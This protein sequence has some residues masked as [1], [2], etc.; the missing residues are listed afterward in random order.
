MDLPKFTDRPRYGNEDSD[1]E[2]LD[3]DPTAEAKLV[4]EAVP[5]TVREVKK[6]QR[7]ARDA[8]WGLL[9][10]IFWVDARQSAYIHREDL[11]GIR[12]EFEQ[13][14][15]LINGK[16]S[17]SDRALPAGFT[18]AARERS[19]GREDSGFQNAMGG[20]HVSQDS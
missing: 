5:L 11:E 9:D 13:A 6:L 2:L 16:L 3:L 7:H 15:Q 1:G 19:R 4:A 17:G 20:R 10:C 18:L 12:D 8:S 14:V